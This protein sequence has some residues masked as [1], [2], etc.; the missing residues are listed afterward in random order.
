MA[1]A[2]G[3]SGTRC[4]RLIFI[5]LAGMRHSASGRSNSAHSASLSSPGRTNTSGANFSACLVT[6]CPSKPSVARR[7][8]PTA[9]GST[10]VCPV[11]NG[12]GDQR[13]PQVSGWI[14]LSAARCNGKAEYRTNSAASAGRGLVS[15][16]LLYLPQCAKDFRS[17]DFRDRR[18]PTQR[19]RNQAATVSSSAFSGHRPPPRTCP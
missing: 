13:A 9:L 4:G 1:S 3:A 2:W 14:P 19:W 11:S 15:T 16:A 17:L 18:L 12:G 7:S 8:A 5:F 10:I 6:V